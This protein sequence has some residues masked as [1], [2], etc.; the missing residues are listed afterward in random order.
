LGA[1]SILAFRTLY[2]SFNEISWVIFYNG[3]MKKKNKRGGGFTLIEILV[4][5]GIIAILAAV[6]LIAINPARQFKLARDSQ[7]QSNVTAILNAVGQNMAENL[8]VFTCA[9]ASTSI[10]TVETIMKKSTGGFDIAS[11]IVPTYIS[12]MPFDPSA[13]GAHFTNTSDY[14]TEYSIIADANG[15]VTISAPA[16]EVAASKISVTR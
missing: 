15:R 6:V 14:D 12:S 1:S 16:T 4:V 8:G 5:I 7:R 2:L 11:C 13:P 9:S 10:P 3:R